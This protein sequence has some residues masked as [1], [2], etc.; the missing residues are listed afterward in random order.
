MNKYFS[1]YVFEHLLAYWQQMKVKLAFGL[2][3]HR[4]AN[5]DAGRFGDF[6]QTSGDIDTVA[7]EV[8]SLY[9]DIADVDA[10][11]IFKPLAKSSGA[12]AST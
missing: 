10:D 4:T 8:F 7:E 6:L 11:P 9:D 12:R 5:A 2:L 3:A 1:R